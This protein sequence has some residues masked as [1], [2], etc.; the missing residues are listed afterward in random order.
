[1]EWEILEGKAQCESCAVPFLD[2]Q[3]YH[4]LLK[5]ESAPWTRTDYCEG[6]WQ[7]ELASSLSSLKEYAA[8]AGRFKVEAPPPPKPEAVSRDHA[9]AL[10]RKLI[11]SQDP[12]KRNAI[13]VLAVMLERKKILKQQQIVRKDAGR[14]LIYSHAQTGE[15]VPVEDPQIRLAD[16]QTI[17]HEV[18][19]LLDQ[20]LAP[21]R[22][23]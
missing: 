17:Q 22:Q 9:Q 23:E 7:R 15:V 6:C 20:E 16:W 18:K 13:F 2:Q 4:T 21:V 12:S 5:L 14:I 8:W 10:F 3:L 1:M 11:A 19:N